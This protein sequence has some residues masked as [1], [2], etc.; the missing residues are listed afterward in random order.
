MT[1]A[2]AFAVVASAAAALALTLAAVLAQ[3]PAGERRAG[4]LI[5]FVALD[6]SGAPVADLRASEVEIRIGDRVR[7]IGSLRRLTTGQMPDVP[8]SPAHLP[9]PYGTNAGVLAGRRIALIVDQESFD[10]AHAPLFREAVE[11]LLP[12]MTAADRMMVAALP[13]GGVRLPFTS[14]KARVRLAI[15]RL[16]GQGSRGE[17][18]SELACRTRLFLESLEEWLRAQPSASAPATVVLFTTGMAGPRRDAPMGLMPGMCELTVDQFRRVATAA[19]GARANFYVLQPADSGL[20]SVQRPTPGGAGDRGSDNPLEG[21]EHLTGVTG[22]VRLPLDAAGAAS[23]RRVARETSAYY[24]AELESSA[25]EPVGRARPLSVRVNRRGVTVRARPEITFGESSRD[26]TASLTV[27]DLLAS[28]DPFVDLR[29][30]VG[31]FTVREPDGS[32]RV[33]VVVEPEDSG[34][35]LTSAGAILIG[36]DDQVASHWFAKDPSE[37]PLL[38][39]LAAAAGSYRLRVAAIDGGGRP[40]AAEDAVDVA[41]VPVG[42]LSLGSLMLGVSRNGSTAPLL[43]FGAEPTAIAYFDIYGGAAGLPLS[44][45][46]EIA[47]DTDGAALATI[48][49]AL[50]RAGEARVV[51][52]GTLP[53][54]ALPPGDYAIRGVVRLES[55]ESG[56]VIRTLRKVAPATR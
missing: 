52:S 12:E 46:V 23:L 42:P 36:P 10:A 17:T 28:N 40:G 44:A 26:R 27:K 9:A 1:Q 19:A 3:T 53:V 48:P 32:L 8:P 25:A 6:A 7:S 45:K 2:R 14:D 20:T 47:R 24:V 49:L 37:R 56:R 18:G 31:A 22:G 39:A 16:S 43:E 11:G 34:V 55:G 13:F 30:R 35:S 38:G 51:A 21:I 29:L 41:L 5:D 15:E 54:G 33:G 50:T 4:P